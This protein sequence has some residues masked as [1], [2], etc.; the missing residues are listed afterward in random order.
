MVFLKSC[1]GA[2]NSTADPRMKSGQMGSVEPGI[3][4]LSDEAI[5]HCMSVSQNDN[6]GGEGFGGNNNDNIYFM[7]CIIF[8]RAC[9]TVHLCTYLHTSGVAVRWHTSEACDG[10]ILNSQVPQK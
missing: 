9:A 10:L 6:S 5:L 2:Q 4:A 1:R 7:Y 3:T 8:P